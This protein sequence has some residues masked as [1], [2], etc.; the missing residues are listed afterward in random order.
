MIATLLGIII[1]VFFV[2]LF[3]VIIVHNIEKG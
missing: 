1:S 3:G 2:F